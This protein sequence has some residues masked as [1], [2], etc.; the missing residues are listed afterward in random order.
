MYRTRFSIDDKHLQFGEY[1]TSNID[2]DPF[3]A[4]EHHSSA[5]ETN[6]GT[7]PSNYI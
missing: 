4:E 7:Y 3:A 6:A 2:R 5:L 1:L